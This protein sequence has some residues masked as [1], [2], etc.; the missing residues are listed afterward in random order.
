MALLCLNTSSFQAL[1]SMPNLR[2]EPSIQI[3]SESLFN[4][5]ALALNAGW[6][7]SSQSLLMPFHKFD[8]H[9]LAI[10]VAQ[11]NSV[12]RQGLDVFESAHDAW[13]ST[14]RLTDDPDQRILLDCSNIVQDKVIEHILLQTCSPFLSEVFFTSLFLDVRLLGPFIRCFLR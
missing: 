10:P 3:S 11:E 13:V 9:T 14:G 2:S 6:D 4:A 8:N 7:K 1:F 12:A 5:T